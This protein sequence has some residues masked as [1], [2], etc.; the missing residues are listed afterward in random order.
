[1]KSREGRKKHYLIETFDKLLIL[2]VIRMIINRQ[3]GNYMKQSTKDLQRKKRKQLA[4]LFL[5]LALILLENIAYHNSFYKPAVIKAA[6]MDFFHLVI[7]RVNFPISYFS[8]YFTYIFGYGYL[9]APIFLVIF[10]VFLF[11]EPSGKNI[12][13]EISIIWGIVNLLLLFYII[14]NIIPSKLYINNL[15]YHGKFIEIIIR[16][17]KRVGGRIIIILSTLVSLFEFF[18]YTLDISHEDFWKSLKS[19][20]VKIGNKIKNRKTGLIEKKTYA[21]GSPAEKENSSEVKTFQRRESSYPEYR[22]QEEKETGYGD[23]SLETRAR[24]SKPGNFEMG[25]GEIIEVEEELALDDKPNRFGREHSLK[26]AKKLGYS[27]GEPIPEDKDFSY[28]IINFLEKYGIRHHYQDKKISSRFVIYLFL[29]NDF[30]QIQFLRKKIEELE[31]KLLPNKLQM[32]I[33]YSDTK[34]IGFAVSKDNPTPYAFTEHFDSSKSQNP[35]TIFIGQQISGDHLFRSLPEFPHLLI[36]GT[37]GSGKS[38]FLNTMLLSL[39][40]QSSGDITRLVLIDPKKVEFEIYK[41][42]PHLAYPVINETETASGILSSSVSLMEERYSLLS[43]KNCRN[44]ADYNK[45]FPGKPLTYLI[46]VIDEFGDLI[47][48]D[49]TDRIKTNLIRLAQKSRAVGIHL[50]LA[51]QR[52]SAKIIDGLIKAN[53]PVRIAFKTSSKIDSRIVLDE[54]GSEELLGKGDMIFSH[55]N[56]GL[57]RI[58]APYIE[59]EEI[60][61]LLDRFSR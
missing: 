14:S 56:L 36:A 26:P 29:I 17:L 58:Q 15:P 40:F 31:F 2:L 32:F 59:T 21:A 42:I 46:I 43:S 13:A 60:I 39:L 41:N 28:T 52:P 11:R 3:A 20:S 23:D 51:T 37:T 30:E 61:R 24:Y 5:I 47:L 22:G 27:D 25:K 33:P 4:I 18:L 10:A 12:K 7:N 35:C 8:F 50:V 16:Y 44:I 53:F 34:F 19:G 55:P 45:Q 54:Q 6:K 48:S 57:V 49:T 1:L 9:L 38:V